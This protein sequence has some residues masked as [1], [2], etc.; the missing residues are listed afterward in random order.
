MTKAKGFFNHSS[1]EWISGDLPGVQIDS[2]KLGI[3]VEHF[4]KM[5]DMPFIIGGISGK[6]TTDHIVHTTAS[7]GI[8]GMDHGF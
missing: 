4:F 6:T 5:G 7:H 2:G 8:Q 1:E 3:I